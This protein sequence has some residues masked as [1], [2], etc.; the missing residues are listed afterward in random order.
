MENTFSYIILCISIVAIILSF[1]T[2]Y[3][4]FLRT[5]KIVIYHSNRITVSV[6]Q[7]RPIIDIFCIFSNLGTRPVLLNHVSLLIK[8]KG[9]PTEACLVNATEITEGKWSVSN[10]KTH[11]AREEKQTPFHPMMLSGKEQIG[12]AL[13]FFADRLVSYR[14]EEN[15]TYIFEISAWSANPQK[16]CATTFFEISFGSEMIAQWY[17]IEMLEHQKKTGEYIGVNKFIKQWSMFGHKE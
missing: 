8:K 3:F 1:G 11:L 17:S 15:K 4:S 12:L 6:F 9:E 10:G 7:Y 16:P 14:F 13:N 2:F 5:G